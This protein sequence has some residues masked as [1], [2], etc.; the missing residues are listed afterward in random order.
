MIYANLANRSRTVSNTTYCHQI[1][2]D[3]VRYLKLSMHWR[4]FGQRVEAFDRVGI[5][6][7]RFDRDTGNSI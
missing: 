1:S 5:H 6:F 4:S 2:N 3:H 7:R